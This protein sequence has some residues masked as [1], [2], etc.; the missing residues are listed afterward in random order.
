MEVNVFR[1]ICASLPIL[2][3]L[4]LMIGFKWSAS[5]AGPIGFF[6]ALIGALVVFKADF[7]LLANSNAKG[8]VMAFY[9]LYI[10]WGA[11]LL[12]NVVDVTGGIE[13]IGATFIEMTRNKI[14]QLLMIGFA[15]VTFLQGVA[16]FGVPVA[17]GAPLLIGM[18]FDPVSA[19]AIALIGHSWAVTF[20]DMAASFASL[21]QATGV[22]G[23][24]S[25]A[26]VWIFH[27]PCWYLLRNVCGTCLRRHE[28]LTARACADP[29]SFL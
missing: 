9:V 22:A 12:Y 24:R 6:V 17:V 29:R 23:S 10:V 2:A 27:S 19:V 26:L 28:G 25:C 20:G 8:F 13:S 16:G 3:I 14:L 18:G 4:V 11:L 5:K 7:H 1:W 21:Q 15:F